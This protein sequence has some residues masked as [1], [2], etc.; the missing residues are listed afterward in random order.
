MSQGLLF[1]PPAVTELRHHLESEKLPILLEGKNTLEIVHRQMAVLA[2]Q[3]GSLEDDRSLAPVLERLADIQQR[4]EKLCQEME[5][6]I[7]NCWMVVGQLQTPSRR[8]NRQW[9]DLQ[10]LC[11][12]LSVKTDQIRNRNEDLN[13]EI[14]D[15]LPN[16]RLRQ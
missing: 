5:E 2:R 14:L 8:P 3:M 10:L 13:Q 4:T 7:D 1:P 16:L 15:L 11:Q 12:T 9:L 6:L